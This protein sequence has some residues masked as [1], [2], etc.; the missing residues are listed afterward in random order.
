MQFDDDRVDTSR[1][2]DVRGG[3]GGRAGGGGMGGMA[4]A[5]ILAALLRGR[6]GRSMFLVVLVLGAY[7]VFG[8]EMLGGTSPDQTATAPEGAASDLATRCNT[9]GAIQQYE[10]CLL[11]KAFN[12]TDEVW[13]QELAQRGQAY[14]SPRLTFFSNSVS[15]ACGPATTAVGPFYCPGDQRIYFDL[16]FARQLGRLGVKGDYANVYIM[17]HEFG[18]HLQN[19][20]GIE[21][22]VRQLQAQDRRNANSY[23]VAMELQADCLAGVWGRLAND[24]GNLSI[25]QAELADAQN[26]AAAVGDDRIQE[27]SGM[28]V[29]PESWTH[30]SSAQRRQW[31]M[32]GFNS[33]DPNR[34]DTF[35]GAL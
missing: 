28:S 14:Q 26:A 20:L 29:D 2:D 23:G 15:T 8:G 31:Y 9:E 3:G 18:H 22:R 6:G 17:A 5:G 24:R 27:Q 32:V 12:E 13:T 34:C 1:I 4:V 10:D 33:A 21:S 25:T 7:L 35:G 30:G 19:I 11:A 16:A